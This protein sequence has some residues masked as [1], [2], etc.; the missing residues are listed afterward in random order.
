M[1]TI[2]M[3][4]GAG[5]I[6]GPLNPFRTGE[7]KMT[8]TS[9]IKNG[10]RFLLIIFTLALLQPAP[11]QAIPVSSP[12]RVLIL[13][14]TVTGGASSQEA[15]AAMLAIPG[16]AVDVVSA[17]NWSAIPASGSGGPTGFGFDQYRALIIGDPQCQN[18]PA[19]IAAMTA[20]NATKALWTPACSGNVIIAG[21]DNAL[22]AVTASVPSAMAGADKSLKRG[23]AFAMDDPT[24]TGFYYAMSCLYHSTATPV[25]VPHLSGFGLFKVHGYGTC[26]DD[27]HIVA[28]HPVFSTVPAMTDADLSNWMCSTHEGFSVWPPSFTVLAI[29]LTNGAYTATDGSNGIPYILVRGQ[30]VSAIGPIELGPPHATNDLGTTH[31]VCA[32]ISTNVSPRTNVLVTFTITS[33]PNA[34]T[35]FTTLTDSNGVACFTYTGTGG[36]GLDYL[37]AKYTNNLGQVLSSGTVTKLWV[38]ACVDIGCPTLECLTDGTW[39]YRFCVTNLSPAPLMA[40]SL[41]DAPVGVSFA[42]STL[43]L[44]PPLATGQGTNLTVTINGPSALTNLCFKFGALTTNE[45]V[46]ACTIPN[47]V[48]LPT[49]CTRVITNSLT[50]VS[51]VG[52]VSTYNYSITVQNVTPTPVK[53][54]GLGAGQSCV[55]FLPGLLDL[56]LPAYGGPSLLFPTQ[57]RTMNLQV[58]R[59]APCPGTNEFYLSTL[60]TNLVGCCSSKLTLPPAKCVTISL[61]VDKSYFL[62]GTPVTMRAIAVG[63]CGL[64]WVRFYDGTTDLGPASPTTGGVYELTLANGFTAGSHWISAVAQLEDTGGGA[65]EVETSEPVELLILPPNDPPDQGHDH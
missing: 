10:L 40:L 64:N 9:K 3:Q 63:P 26:F 28:A 12:P 18:G 44:S 42:P 2:Q 35:N 60:D 57:T 34:V 27:A 54:V 8:S 25:I 39:T 1:N 4:T 50:F 51:T 61:P 31:T 36:L 23:I 24:K 47:C 30:G 59:T 6:N 7:I 41:S 62:A 49:C 16:C 14:E 38:G 13:D 53:Y 20:L 32:T 17:A 19:Y 56:T 15:V 29:A 58:Q 52:N 43:W 48:S 11:V 65:G 45:L 33:G 21:V 46:P 5:S 22:H 37:I 55:T